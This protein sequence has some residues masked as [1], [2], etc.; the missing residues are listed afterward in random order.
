MKKVRRLPK[1][2]HRHQFDHK[3]ISVEDPFQPAAH[4]PTQRKD[5]KSPNHSLSGVSSPNI[6]GH[7]SNHARS[8]NITIRC[9]QEK[10]EV[11]KDELSKAL[12]DID[13]R[14]THPSS[15]PPNANIT[16]YNPHA[17]DK[18]GYSD[19]PQWLKDEFKRWHRELLDRDL[20]KEPWNIDAKMLGLAS[21]KALLRR[22]A[23]LRP[24]VLGGV[25]GCPQRR[26]M[27]HRAS[28]YSPYPSTTQLKTHAVQ[29]AG[30]MQRR[31]A[32][33]AAMAQARMQET[34]LGDMRPRPR[35]R[36]RIMECRR[37]VSR[38][39]TGKCHNSAS[40]QNNARPAAASSLHLLLGRLCR[41]QASRR[42]EQQGIVVS[43]KRKTIAI[44]STQNLKASDRLAVLNLP[45]S[46]TII[47]V[48]I[49]VILVFQR[50]RLQSML[51]VQSTSQIASPRRRKRLMTEAGVAQGPQ[52][53][54]KWS[55]SG[56][57]PA[58]I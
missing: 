1:P 5:T 49:I 24:S 13:L 36:E 9:D 55:I 38:V 51:S 52:R 42:P 15:S 53:W 3:R 35:P 47:T 40:Q 10:L 14:S 48:S 17:S 20:E 27:A 44:D 21:C 12:W 18:I 25:R 33:V 2:D 22:P 6:Q 11:S 30:A 54:V 28:L 50:M 46:S 58:V 31:P 32:W 37:K 7:A 39:P 4:P 45:L 41:N 29:S 57:A 8:S 56:S 34:A 23:Q 43:S 19:W 26:V 16:S